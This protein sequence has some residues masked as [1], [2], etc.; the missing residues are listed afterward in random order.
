[1]V[2]SNEAE[3][4]PSIS[5]TPQSELGV[6]CSFAC[7]LQLSPNQS[8][9][10][11]LNFQ[12]GTLSIE[13]WWQCTTP[14]WLWVAHRYKQ[15]FK[16]IRLRKI[17]FTSRK[18]RSEVLGCSYFV[19]RLVRPVLIL[20]LLLSFKHIPLL[21]RSYFTGNY[22]IGLPLIVDEQH[23]LTRCWIWSYFLSVAQD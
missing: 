11:A 18:H 23:A 12:Q 17:E 4:L 5:G 16:I 13:F 19:L 3:N 14:L 22:L 21:S 8:E 20:L 15:Q 6:C 1:M 7:L 9:P 2:E 10:L